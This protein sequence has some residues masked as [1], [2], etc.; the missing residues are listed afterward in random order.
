V[1]VG[2]LL[3]TFR[4]SPQPALEAA[5]AALEAGLDGVFAYDHLWPM[6]SP[7]RPALAPFEVLAAV[8][9]SVGALRVGPLVARIG[10]VDDGVLLAQLRALR[11][12][13]GGRLIAG[14]GTGDRKSV[15]EN[16]RYGI[17]IGPPEARRASLRALATQLVADGTEVWI[18]DGAAATRAVA[19]EV[20]CTLNLWDADPAAVGVAC[21]AATVSWA[22]PAPTVDGAFD[23]AA[24][25]TL[26]A[27]L[28]RAGATWAVFTPSTPI[29][30]LGRLRR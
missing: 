18:G 1:R 14:L 16:E 7:D 13:A 29:P 23:G 25:S 21:A 20:G 15:D 22:G 3:P 28:E 10:L 4:R 26:L 5:R 24:T 6:G 11:I 2:I 17:P 27:S 9:A 8:A 30:A 12:V 19:T